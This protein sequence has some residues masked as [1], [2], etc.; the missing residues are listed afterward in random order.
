MVATD[1]DV[2]DW[3]QLIRAEY[4]EMP[5]LSLTRQQAQR[6]WGLDPETCDALLDTMVETRFLRR[7]SHDLYVRTDV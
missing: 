1:V 7:T 6:L 3:L 2:S 5:G 4:L